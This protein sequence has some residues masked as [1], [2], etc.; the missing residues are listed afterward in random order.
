MASVLKISLAGDRAAKGAAQLPN[1]ALGD[2]F[3]LARG[4]E[5]TLR[6]G[7]GCQVWIVTNHSEQ[8][9]SLDLPTAMRDLLE[10]YAPARKQLALPAYGGPC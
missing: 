10:D 9:H 3:H 1:L 4:V 5:A 2:G 8:A 7:Q 6:L